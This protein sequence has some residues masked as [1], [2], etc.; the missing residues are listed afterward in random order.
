MQIKQIEIYG[1][2]NPEQFYKEASIFMM[3][4]VLEGW[5]MAMQEAMQFGCIP[6]AFNTFSA[7]YDMIQDKKNGYVINDNDYQSYSYKL[8][9]LMNNDELRYQMAKEAINSTQ[10]FKAATIANIWLN[11]M[12]NVHGK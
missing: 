5:P 9:T 6:I 8:M 7:V 11:M 2:S 10:K 12:A 4:S 1:K 3:T